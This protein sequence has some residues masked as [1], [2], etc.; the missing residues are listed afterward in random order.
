MNV[1]LVAGGMHAARSCVQGRSSLETFVSNHSLEQA[2]LAAL[3]NKM[4]VSL[5]ST[6]GDT[7]QEGQWQ[8][9]AGGQTALRQQ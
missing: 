8:G 6:L 1:L 3:G 4:E 9:P 2:C 7:G 5:G